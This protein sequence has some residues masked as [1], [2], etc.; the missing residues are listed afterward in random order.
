MAATATFGAVVAVGTAIMAGLWRVADWLGTPTWI[1]IG[2]WLMPTV[3]VATWSIARAPVAGLTDDDDDTWLGH[4]I[5]WALV[6]PSTPRPVAL[7]IF[8]ALVFGGP[9][10]WAVAAAALATITGLG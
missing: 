6:G 9:V 1:I 4:C 5:R 10:G 8:L 2:G 7:R 3:G